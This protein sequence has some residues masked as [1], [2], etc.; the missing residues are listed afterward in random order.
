MTDFANF[1]W[2]SF[3]INI[4][5][6]LIFFILGILFSLW[7]IPRF[8]LRLMRKRNK[9]FLK[10]KLASIIRELCEF[11][12]L[13]P[14]KDKELN[15]E[16]ITICTNIKDHKNY[17][18]VG[19]CPVNV[20][21]KV[22][23]PKMSLVIYD[24]FKELKPDDSYAELSKEYS[25]LKMFRTEIEKILAVHSLYLDDR[26]IL[27]ISDLCS[28]IRAQEIKIYYKLGVRRTFRKNKL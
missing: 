14:F 25:R 26:L 2:N 15:R 16:N 4:W 17:F 28:D 22:S 21:S 13:S 12:I 11:L 1:D 24:Y 6:G 20:F 8:T 5:A 19:L 23:F 18:F 7:L 9:T 3:W 27:E 10:R